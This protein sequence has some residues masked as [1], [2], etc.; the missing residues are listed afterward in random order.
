LTCCFECS[1]VEFLLLVSGNVSD[2]LI[3]LHKASASVV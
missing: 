2:D 1:S 3:Q